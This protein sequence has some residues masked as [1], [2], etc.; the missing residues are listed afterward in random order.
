MRLI[1]VCLDSD[2]H[3]RAEAD[4]AD[5]VISVRL[6]RNRFAGRS[7]SKRNLESRPKAAALR[8]L[9]FIP[10]QLGR[11]SEK[12]QE[13]VVIIEDFGHRGLVHSFCNQLRQFGPEQTSNRNQQSEEEKDKDD[14]ADC[15]RREN[16]EIHP[17]AAAPSLYFQKQTGEKE[18]E[19]L[20]TEDDQQK[21]R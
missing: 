21:K 11:V 6:P 16:P 15:D 3:H 2:R 5:R 12:N 14:S 4:L 8:F 20:Y 19:K 9:L 7:G 18:A 13:H 17:K 1:F 10:L